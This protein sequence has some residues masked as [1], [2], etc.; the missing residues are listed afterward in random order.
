MLRY[1]VEARHDLEERVAQTIGDSRPQPLPERDR[2]QVDPIPLRAQF[3]QPSGKGLGWRVRREGND[4]PLPT[5]FIPV[6]L[7]EGVD[8]AG[9]PVVAAVG[10][11]LQ[12]R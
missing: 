4:D 7:E 12:G 2:A 11:P 3:A 8:L 5:L 9:H 1:L 10:A 6:N